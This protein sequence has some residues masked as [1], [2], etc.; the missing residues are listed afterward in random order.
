M[1]GLSPRE[2]DVLAAAATGAT[3]AAV[4][5]ELFLSERTVEQHLRSIFTK[6]DLGEHGGSNRR[7]RAAA[8]WWEHRR[9]RESA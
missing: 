1:P 5:A 2:N 9:S 8:I 6:L 7:V 3:N 4:A